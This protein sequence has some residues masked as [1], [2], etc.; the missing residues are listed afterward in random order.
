[1]R[2]VVAVASSTLLACLVGC[3]TP[4]VFQERPTPSASAAARTRTPASTSPT[5]SSPSWGFCRD[6]ATLN[7]GIIAFTADVG[8]GTDEQGRPLD[9]TDLKLRVLTLDYLQD[10]LRPNAPRPVASDLDTLQVAVVQ[11]GR[12]LLADSSLPEIA[13]LMYRPKTAAAR[14]RLIGYREAACHD[15]Q[16]SKTVVRTLADLR[17]EPCRALDEQQARDLGVGIVGTPEQLDLEGLS[18]RWR[19]IE[20]R[21]SLYL[22]AYP[23]IDHTTDPEIADRF[24]PTKVAG[25]RAFMG[26]GRAEGGCMMYVSV[27]Q[28][29]SIRV[30]V[31][32]SG[33]DTGA[34]DCAMANK[35]AT[36]V[37]AN[38]R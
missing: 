4:D 17:R 20:I 24:T 3:S 15:V 6:L 5:P 16:P 10:S 37:L 13:A 7:V 35:L 21:E 9:R 36:G 29:Q 32:Q 33:S 23:S 12:E 2:A 14:E 28:D 18:C 26:V 34:Q 25:R 27:A 38:L 30:I 11:A 19:S 22:T 8:Q 31:G 1:M